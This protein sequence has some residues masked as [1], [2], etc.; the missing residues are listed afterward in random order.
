MKSPIR[1]MSGFAL[2]V[3][4]FAVCDGPASAETASSA[5][6]P[7]PPPLILAFELR[8]EVVAPVE[9]EQGQRVHARGERSPNGVLIRFYRLE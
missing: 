3:L 8:A 4:A 1:P 2:C 7:A 9:I 6:P 5:A